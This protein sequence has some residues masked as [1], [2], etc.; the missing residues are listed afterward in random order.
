MRSTKSNQAGWTSMFDGL[1]REAHALFR[2]S[3]ADD[4]DGD[5]EW[6]IG[7]WLPPLLLRKPPELDE[8]RVHAW[9]KV[10]RAGRLP[11]LLL[12]WIAGLD[13]F[14]VLDGAH[15][16]VAAI[17]EGVCPMALALSA[18]RIEPRRTEYDGPERR[19]V[20]TR[21]WPLGASPP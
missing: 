11:P 18:V 8:G 12:W 14:V 6:D 5:T 7:D 10:A 15:R 1:A 4:E 3:G 20:I 9:Q 16:L 2:R 13:R 17:R 21:A 19:I